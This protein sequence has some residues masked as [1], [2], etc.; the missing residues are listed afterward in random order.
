VAKVKF[1]YVIPD[2][3][4]A[5][6]EFLNPEGTLARVEGEHYLQSGDYEG[7][8]RAFTLAV[9]RAD[10]FRY[11]RTMRAQVRLHLAESQRQLGQMAE[12]EQTARDGLKI[13]E[14]AGRASLSAQLLDCLAEIYLEQKNYAAAESVT[15]EANRE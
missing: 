7:A 10:R 3:V 9:L 5:G 6:N 8:A 4:A 11:S 15:Q 13:A 12:A 2:W 1:P 14:E